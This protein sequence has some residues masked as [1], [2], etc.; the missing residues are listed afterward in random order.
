M[1][2]RPRRHLT[3]LLNNA[4]MLYILFIFTE[5]VSFVREESASIVEDNFDV[6][7]LDAES[8]LAERLVLKRREAMMIIIKYYYTNNC[9]RDWF[10]FETF[11]LNRA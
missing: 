9:K 2:G 3:R 10:V 11:L 7:V 5:K 8:G 4:D 6:S 1:F